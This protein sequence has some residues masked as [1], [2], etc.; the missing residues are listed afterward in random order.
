MKKPMTDAE[1]GVLIIGG[2]LGAVRTAEQLR[3]S[4]FTGPITIVSGETHLP[5]DRPPLSK[6][7]LRDAEKTIDAVVLKPREFYDE[8]QIE[9]RLGSEV[10][11]LDPAA[12]TVTLSD[13]GTLEYGEVII[14]TG[15]VPRR[16]PTFPDLAGVHVLRTADD[17]FALRGDAENA[18]RAVV[19]GAGFIGCEVAATLRANG[20]EV[21]LVEPQ[22]APLVA[23]IGQQLGDLVA[24]LHRNE[25]VDV[26]V[27]VGV[28]SVEGQDRVQTVTLSDGTRLD[29]DLVVLGIGSRPAIDW[30]DGSG[31]AVDNGVVCD[32]VGA[33]GTPH[34][35]ALG[36]VAAWAGADGR[37]N[38]VEHWSNVADQVRALVPALLGQETSANTVAVPYFWSDQYDVKIQSLGHLGSSDTVHL[39]SDDGRKFLA[40]LERD[41]VLTGVVGCGMAGPVMKMRAKIAA[42]TPIAEVLPGS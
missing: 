36:D 25:G 12:R 42:A 41:G 23:A 17:S 37:P 18:R 27:G 20:V 34:V 30:L 38:R 3:R 22:P 9:L 15:L 2:G 24:R 11:A 28:D 40:Y 32:A 21:V 16:I 10:T 39:I 35:W 4:E 29:A 1:R 33:T 14:A 19:V 6:D 31:V 13:G 26:R 7:V 5:Y 8:N